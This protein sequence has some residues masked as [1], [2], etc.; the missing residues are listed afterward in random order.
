MIFA[1]LIQTLA[2]NLGVKTGAFHLASVLFCVYQ[3]LHNLVR[4]HIH[5]IG[6]FCIG[7]H[8]AELCREEYPRYVNICL[9]IIA[10]L[11]VISDDIPEG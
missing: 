9:W 4:I 5:P 2:A 6:Q 3:I 8:L 7:K 10:E 1:L 11:A